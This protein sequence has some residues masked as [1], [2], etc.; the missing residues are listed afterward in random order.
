MLWL[1]EANRLID[2]WGKEQPGSPHLAIGTSATAALAARIATALQRAYDQGRAS[3]SG[4]GT[5]GIKPQA[6][7][8]DLEG[9]IVDVL[10]LATR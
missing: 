10:V 2:N 5:P 9:Q 4:W 3:R 6:P 7:P 1:T 8:P